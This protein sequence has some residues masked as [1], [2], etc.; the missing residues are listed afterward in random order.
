MTRVR[1]V[2]A[3]IC[4]SIFAVSMANAKDLASK[5]F[6]FG[7]AI[8]QWFAGNFSVSLLNRDVEKPASTLFKAYADANL[9]PKFAMGVFVAYSN[10][11]WQYSTMSSQWQYY[12]N[13]QPWLGGYITDVAI[14]HT[15]DISM[16][17]VGGSL[18][19]R[20]VVS[21]QVVLKPAL[22]VSYRQSSSSYK[23]AQASALGIN[24]SLEVQYYASDS[25]YYFSEFGAMTQPVGGNNDTN[26]TSGPIF[27]I[28]FGIGL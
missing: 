18:K 25:H 24:G 16:I 8:G 9:T 13:S 17:E 1:K 10:M 4:I 23:Y 15:Y 7:V 3:A 19:P 22:S 21:P 20:F 11:N 14:P 12:D 26:I 2:F 5:P 28:L 27:Y 6:D